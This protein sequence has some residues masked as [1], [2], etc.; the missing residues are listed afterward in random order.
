MCSSQFITVKVRTQ[1]PWGGDTYSYMLKGFAPSNL[2]DEACQDLQ[3]ASWSPKRMTRLRSSVKVDRLNIQ[4]ELT[5]QFVSQDRKNLMS[6][7]KAVR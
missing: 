1:N 2:E 6:Q 7:L 3:A 5:F 4:D